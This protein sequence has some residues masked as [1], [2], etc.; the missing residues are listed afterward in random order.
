MRDERAVEP[1]IQA[2]KDDD[3]GVRRNAAEAL[4]YMGDERAVEP[5]NQALKDD[6]NEVRKAA[7]KALAKIEEVPPFVYFAIIVLLVIVGT[8]LTE[9]E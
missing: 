3:N 5:L 7:K 1:P 9:M 2:L 4:G 6:D 8:I